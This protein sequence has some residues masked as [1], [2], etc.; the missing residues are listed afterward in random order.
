M[1]TL[2]IPEK[3]VHAGTLILVN[4]Q[5]PYHAGNAEYS[6]APVGA[7][8]SNVLL[9]RRASVLLS[10]LMNDIDGWTRI[11]AVSGWRSEREQRD[12]YDQSLREN[13]TAFT[14]QFVAK[15]NHSEHQTGLAIDLGLKKADIDFIRPDFP[16]SGICQSF[17]EKAINYGFIERYPKGKQAI[18]RIAQEPWHFRYVG[19]PHAAIM[20]ELGLALEEYHAFLKQYPYGKRCFEYRNGNQNVAI[21]YVA[22]TSGTNAKLEIEADIPYTVSGNNA[23]GFVL[24]EWR[25]GDDKR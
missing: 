13:G 14:E 17:R 18:T 9:E 1:K 11:S 21:S 23:D 2:V 24:T 19:V 6:L 12:I 3:S 16:Y 5:Y 20:A 22:A 7:D 10:E 15:P 8:G 4:L 25:N